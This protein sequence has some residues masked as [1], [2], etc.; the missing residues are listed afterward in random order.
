MCSKRALSTSKIHHLFLLCVG[1][2]RE[3]RDGGKATRDQRKTLNFLSAQSNTRTNSQPLYTHTH[4]TSITPKQNAHNIKKKGT[5]INK[6]MRTPHKTERAKLPGQLYYPVQHTK[7]ASSLQT[8]NRGS[9]SNGHEIFYEHPRKTTSTESHGYRKIQ[10]KTSYAVTV[11]L[12]YYR[13]YNTTTPTLN[14][15]GNKYS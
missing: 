7:N 12:S 5:K 2:R 4:Q 13:M 11:N 3:K 14:S 9:T 10:V 1:Q 15:T 6:C 8:H